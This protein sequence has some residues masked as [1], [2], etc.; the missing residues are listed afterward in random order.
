MLITVKN[1]N[2]R[3][4]KAELLD[5]TDSYCDYPEDKKLIFRK[6]KKYI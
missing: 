5:L 6:R 3:K 1:K 2:N 4:I